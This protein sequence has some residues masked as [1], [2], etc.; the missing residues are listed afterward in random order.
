MA[1]NPRPQLRARAVRPE[2]SLTA[3]PPRSTL[4]VIPS[5]HAECEWVRGLI[6][7]QFRCLSNPSTPA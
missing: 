2:S 3:L 1:H 5:S 4:P 7:R 6:L